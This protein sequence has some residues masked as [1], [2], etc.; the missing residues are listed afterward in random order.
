MLGDVFEGGMLDPHRYISI[1]QLSR[2]HV[3]GDCNISVHAVYLSIA[4][5]EKENGPMGWG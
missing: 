2:Q 3:P 4:E 5:G 1:G